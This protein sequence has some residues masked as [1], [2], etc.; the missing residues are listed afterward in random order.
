MN[1]SP[2]SVCVVCLGL[3]ASP[4][5]HADEASHLQAAKKLL[6][7]AGME[8]VFTKTVDQSLTQQVAENPALAELKPVMKAFFD[9]Y[10]SWNALR[11][12]MAQLYAAQFTEE[13]LKDITAFYLTPSGQ[14]MARITPDLMASG[15][16]LGQSKVQAHLGELQDMIEAF[17]A[18]KK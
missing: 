18:N 3:V 5:V 6:E 11:D 9:K 8:A 12:D 17:Q 1:R 13:E 4:M 2:F 14:K 15:S 10:M 7:A 16:A